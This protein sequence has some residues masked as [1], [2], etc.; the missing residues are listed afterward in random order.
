VGYW[1]RRTIM[2]IGE[3]GG[4]YRRGEPPSSTALVR[5]RYERREVVLI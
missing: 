3:F 2:P 1:R 4:I 5:R